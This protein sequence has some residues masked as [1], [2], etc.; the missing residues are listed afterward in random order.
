MMVIMCMLV[1]TTEKQTIVLN[2][3]ID[4]QQILTCEEP[5]RRTA[6]QEVK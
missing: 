4:Y 5:V 6:G 1:S 3:D 2:F